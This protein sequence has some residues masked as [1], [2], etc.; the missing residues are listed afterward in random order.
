MIDGNRLTEAPLPGPVPRFEIPGWRERF[1]V[2]AGIT[3]RGAAGSEDFDLG[4]W[5]AEPVGEVMGRWRAFRSVE[6]GFDQFVMAHQVHGPEVRWH[7]AGLGWTILDGLDGHLTGAQGTMLMVTVADCIPIYL[8]DS[9]HRAIGL[10]HGGWRGTA[11]GILRRGVDL[12]GKAAGVTPAEIVMHC[13]VGICGEC[14][15]VGDEVM[16]ACGAA[17]DGPG[18]WHIDLRARLADQAAEVGVEQITSSTWCSAHDRSR[19]FSHRASRGSDGRMVAY[20]GI[21]KTTA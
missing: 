2:I 5:T 7:E 18:P 9:R 15:E 17:A 4:L 11:G 20:L 14:Y 1:G 3:G 13:G 21:A 19:F 6:S 16:K 10:L 12:L 8:V